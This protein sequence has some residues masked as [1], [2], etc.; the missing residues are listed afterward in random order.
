M[1]YRKDLIPGEAFCIFIFFNFLILDFLRFTV[2]I[3]FNFIFDGVTVKID[4]CENR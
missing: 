2:C 1:K 3:F 4:S